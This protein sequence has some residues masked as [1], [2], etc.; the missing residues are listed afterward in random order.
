MVVSLDGSTGARVKR[1]VTTQPRRKERKAVFAWLSPSKE[2]IE[3]FGV[4]V[5]VGFTGHG[6]VTTTD[7]TGK[8]TLA[9]VFPADCHFEL[10]VGK[11]EV[12]TGPVFIWGHLCGV[13]WGLCPVNQVWKTGKVLT[14][15]RSLVL[16]L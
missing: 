5:D 4:E 7:Q 1:V 10:V 13:W 15:I 12:L 2:F 14:M 9:D 6:S 11:D 3:L 16:M 8:V